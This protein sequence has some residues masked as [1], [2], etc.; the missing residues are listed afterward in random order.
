MINKR[1]ISCLLKL[2][3]KEIKIGTDQIK[4]Q[5]NNKIIFFDHLSCLIY[6]K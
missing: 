3:S 6:K 5:F 2:S 1:Y 4:K